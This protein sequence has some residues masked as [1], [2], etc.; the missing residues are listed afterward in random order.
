MHYKCAG[1]KGMWDLPAGHRSLENLDWEPRASNE[2][3]K[4]WNHV[5]IQRQSYFDIDRK[6]W[7]KKEGW[8]III[9]R[10]FTCQSG[11]ILAV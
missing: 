3:R 4:I 6:G 11:K 10:H 9:H 1:G 5:L 8:W 7:R 2:P